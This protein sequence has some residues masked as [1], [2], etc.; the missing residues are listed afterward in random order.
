M[1]TEHI[2]YLSRSD[3]DGEHVLVNVSSAGSS[4]LDL[5]LLATEGESPYIATIR[6]SRISKLRDKRNQLSDD[7]WEDVLHSTLLQRRIQRPEASALEKLEVLATLNGDQLSLIFRNNISGITQKLGEVVFK[8]DENQELDIVGWAGT[9]V[10]RSNGLDG[11]FRDLISKYDEQSKKIEKLNFQLEDLIKAK[12]QHENSLLQNF[13]ELLNTKKLKIRDQQRLLAGAKADP[14]QAATLQN[15][16]STLKSRAATASRA[17]KRKANGSHRASESSEESGFEEKAPIRKPESDL[18]E[19][20]NTPEH[21][22]QELTED[23]SDDDLESA[24][25]AAK[26]PDRNKAADGA[27]GTIGEEMQLDTLPPPRDLPFGE[28]GRR[29]QTRR[30]VTDDKSTITHEACNEDEETDDDEL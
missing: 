7:Q 18:S 28:G 10:K 8:K 15:A 23:E 9:A 20:M 29:V 27:K 13:R 24:P 26:L 30:S 2:L 17:G 25:P 19:K 3:S 1:A 11:E 6:Q 21:S 16:R 5:K 12:I 14:K 4:A 22:D